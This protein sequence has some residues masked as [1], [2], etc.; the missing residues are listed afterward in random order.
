MGD[1]FHYS[2]SV[3][4]R[5]AL[6]RPN[7]AQDG[8]DITAPTARA[9]ANEEGHC[10]TNEVVSSHHLEGRARARSAGLEG[11]RGKCAVPAKSTIDTLCSLNGI[12]YPR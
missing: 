9:I 6:P 1:Y 8:P 2:H 5:R 11:M 10:E 12:A 4:T 3:F 7:Q